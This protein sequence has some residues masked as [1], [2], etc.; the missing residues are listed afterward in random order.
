MVFLLA[1][2]HLLTIGHTMSQSIVGALVKLLC[3]KFCFHG[4]VLA[5]FV[6]LAESIYFGANV[7]LETHG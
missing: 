3:T 1:P 6:C 4:I 2:E 7:N 5:L